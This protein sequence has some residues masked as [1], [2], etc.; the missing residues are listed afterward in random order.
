MEVNGPGSV[1]GASPLKPIPPEV[2]APK[3][4]QSLPAP[5]QDE[6]E[7]S[8][9]GKMLDKLN[10]SSEVHA[11]RLAQIKAAIDAGEY[12]TSAKLEAAV[13]KLLD[14]IGVDGE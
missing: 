14:E 7:I 8:S 1:S 9:A 11:E 3:P 12:E 4:E 5:T 2:Q 13:Q 10:Q 6:V